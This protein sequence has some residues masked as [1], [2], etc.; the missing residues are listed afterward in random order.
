MDIVILKDGNMLGG[1]AIHFDGA[2]N[3]RIDWKDGAWQVE[4]RGVYKNIDGIRDAD[5]RKVVERIGKA[6]SDD[7]VTLNGL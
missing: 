4:T 6:F 7:N 1:Y 2:G 5:I 3:G